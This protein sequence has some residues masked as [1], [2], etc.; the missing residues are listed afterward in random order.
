MAKKILT[1]TLYK[2]ELL[3]DIRNLTYLT[4]RSRNNGNNHEEVANMQA[5]EDDEDNNQILRSIGN[6]LDSL[7][8][9]LSEYFEV[10]SVTTSN[11]ELLE[12]T[13]DITIKLSMPS[14]YN[15]STADSI[16][17]AC[18][19]Y[20]VNISTADWFAI[21][22]KAD[23]G[24][25]VSKAAANLEMIREAANKRIRPTRTSVSSS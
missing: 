19:Q 11:N 17:S 6:A 8:T 1:I 23:A 22:N 12:S 25:Y 24:D 14:N 16:T 20:I 7:K 13:G 3:Y 10:S 15:L 9:K 2:S 4:G 5:S 21:T 18:H